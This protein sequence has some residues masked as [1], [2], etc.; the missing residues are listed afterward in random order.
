[1]RLAELVT[2]ALC[3]SGLPVAASAAIITNAS[4]EAPVTGSFVYN[5]V[6]P[7]GGWTFS[8]RS[9]VASGIFF[10]APPPDGVQ[11]AFLQQAG[12]QGSSL[13]S[14]TQTVSG[15]ALVSQTL[16]FYIAL[17]P[18]GFAADP[19]TVS[20]GS[21]TLGTFTPVSTAFTLVTINFVPLTT[22]GVLRFQSAAGTGAD[23]DTA[24]DQ[25]SLSTVP[26]PATY[27]LMGAALAGI[28]FL[29]RRKV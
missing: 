6:D 25:V 16:S 26:E 27:G 20:Y 7:T 23:L 4:F 29:R 19:I 21:Q 22:S 17:R 14:I 9:G 8:G 24:I 15:V 2:I 13:S 5:P 18:G 3:V 11:A 1:M 10:A 12:D 28:G